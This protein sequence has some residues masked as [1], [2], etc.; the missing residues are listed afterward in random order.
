MFCDSKQTQAFVVLMHG[1]CR[2][3][4]KSLGRQIGV[5][6]IVQAPIEMAQEWSGYIMG[7][8]SPFGLARPMQVH[9]EKS[10]L[11]L[12]HKIIIN[13]GRHDSYLLMEPKDIARAFT[14]E[15]AV[16]AGFPQIKVVQCGKERPPPAPLGGGSDAAA[17][18]AAAAAAGSPAAD[19][20][21][22]ASPISPSTG[23]KRLVTGPAPAPVAPSL[24]AL[25]AA[26]AS[27]EL[28]ASATTA[29]H[30]VDALDTALADEI[31]RAH[32]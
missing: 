12:P 18:A 10:I 4:M 2:V 25:Q 22:A 15:A 20:T 29:Q 6:K 31:G 21:G 9:I 8:T 26:A 23:T 3:D 5:P 13:A 17:T 11:D 24:A 32:V 27:A 16:A 28:P 7:G 30:I 19:A 14:T 1:D